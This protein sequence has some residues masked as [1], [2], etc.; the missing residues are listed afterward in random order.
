M[1]S[2]MH[3]VDWIMQQVIL[4]KKNVLLIKLFNILV[5]THVFTTLSSCSSSHH[6]HRRKIFVCGPQSG[7]QPSCT[8]W[9]GNQETGVGA[10]RAPGF[11]SWLCERG[12]R[13][14]VCCG[15]NRLWKESQGQ[16]GWHPK[17]E[18]P[19]VQQ[20]WGY[21]WAHLPEWGLCVAQPEGKI[22]LWS[23][24][25]KYDLPFSVIESWKYHGVNSAVTTFSKTKLPQLQQL[26]SYYQKHDAAAFL[27]LLLLLMLFLLDG[28]RSSTT[29]MNVIYPSCVANTI[30]PF[31]THRRVDQGIIIMVFVSSQ[32]VFLFN[33]HLSLF[34]LLLP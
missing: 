19:K 5:F 20:S 11:R 6:V 16:Q 14:W 29:I 8:G 17:D 32:F 10:F 3:K 26:L 18:P 28:M 24:I 12:A 31:R 22:L 7:Q 33:L 30:K 9:L 25:C 27:L 13:W 1:M 15:I 21:G 2:S 34:V 23:Y 4:T